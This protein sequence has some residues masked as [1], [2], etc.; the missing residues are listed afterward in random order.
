MKEKEGEEGEEDLYLTQSAIKHKIYAVMLLVEK[1]DVV[2][3]VKE[4]VKKVKK[5]KKQEK[6]MIVMIVNCY[7]NHNKEKQRSQTREQL[8]KEALY[9]KKKKAQKKC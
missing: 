8:A 3:K 5:V 6:E 2:V 7:Q 4:A 9:E 1:V